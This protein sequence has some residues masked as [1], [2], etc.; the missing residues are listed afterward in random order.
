[1]GAGKQF[2]ARRARLTQIRRGTAGVGLA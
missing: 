1:V 2:R